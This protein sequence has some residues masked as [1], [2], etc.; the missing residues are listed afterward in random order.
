MSRVVQVHHHILAF[1]VI[2]YPADRELSF[3]MH[4]DVILRSKH[5]PPP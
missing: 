4:L 2:A 1:L 5:T 3:V